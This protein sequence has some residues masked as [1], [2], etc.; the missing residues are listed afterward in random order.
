MYYSFECMRSPMMRSRLEYFVARLFE[1][2]S[3]T[4]PVEIETNDMDR[5]SNPGG[6]CDIF[7][8]VTQYSSTTISEQRTKQEA[9]SLTLD[10]M[11]KNR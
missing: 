8:L 7:Y 2:C 9:V 11:V 10:N 5:S 4:L 6:W 1:T 3:K